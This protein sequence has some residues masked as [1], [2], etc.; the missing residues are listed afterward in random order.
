MSTNWI[1]QKPISFEALA[2]FNQNG[3]EARTDDQG[4]G[5]VLTDG[6]NYLHVYAVPEADTVLLER[7]GDNDPAAILQ[8]VE[9]AFGIT[10]VSEYDD[11]YGALAERTLDE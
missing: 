2:A 8:A 7:N 10:L 4:K 1:P 5:L 11:E 3:V 9:D 6:V